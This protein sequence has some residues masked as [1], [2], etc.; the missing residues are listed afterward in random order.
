MPHRS[1]RREALPGNRRIAGVDVARGL[2]LLGM[3]ATHVLPLTQLPD[4]GSATPTWVAWLFAGKSSALFAIL[5]GVGLG[6][7]TGGSSPHTGARLA[8]DRRS[9]AIR[10]LLIAGI[11]LACGSLDTNVAIILAHYGVLFLAATLFLGMPLRRLWCWAAGWL[12]LSP[13]AYFMLLPWVRG[14]VVPPDVGG[15]PDFLDILQPAT[16][17][18]D[19]LVTGYYPVL[20]WTGFI[21]LGLA[22]GRCRISHPPVALAFLLGG[23]ALAWGARALSNAMV[24]GNAAAHRALSAATGNSELPLGTALASG[25]GLAGV[26]QT[27]WWFAVSAPHSS[28]PLDLLHVAGTAVAVLGACQLVSM[29][30]AAV[31]GQIGESLLWPL[32]GAG[33]ATLTLYAAHLVALDLLG[34]ITAAMP[35]LGV[36]LW[37]AVVS[38]LAGI[39]LKWA[40]TRGPMEYVVHTIAHAGS[41]GQRKRVGRS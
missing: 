37:F 10:A 1:T 17:A 13:V 29:A 15:S 7:L 4:D 35:R 28:A 33:S 20:V 6:L 2:A 21:L 34:T 41:G 24:F 12:L 23:A 19:L 36:Y 9:V 26:E 25:R 22:L 11:G 40:G 16:F 31:L 3:M 5:A 27:P 14:H 39:A 38:L 18:A 30:L 8:A 32:S